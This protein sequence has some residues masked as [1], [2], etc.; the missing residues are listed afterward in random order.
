MVASMRIR[1]SE[2][3]L[4]DLS[5]EN[6]AALAFAPRVRVFLLPFW[7]LRGF[8]RQSIRFELATTIPQKPAATRLFPAAADDGP[9]A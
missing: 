7:F 3:L 5:G 8:T 6:L 1:V 4:D 2:D 9:H